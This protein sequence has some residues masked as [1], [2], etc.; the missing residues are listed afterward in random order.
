MLAGSPVLEPLA[1]QSPAVLPPHDRMPSEILALLARPDSGLPANTQFAVKP[2]GPRLS[3]DYI[4]QPYLA[5]GADRFGTFVGGGASLYWSDMLGNR[6]LVTVLQV[7]GG[8]KDVSALV[9]YLNSSHRWNWGVAAQQVP[10]YSGAYGASI[11]TNGVYIER[12]QLLRQ[13]NRQLAVMTAYPFN[14]VQ[15]VELSAGVN[16]ISF[17]QQ[18]ETRYTA[19]STGQLL[20]DTTES[21]QHPAAINLATTSGALVFDNSFFGATS[22]ILGQ[23]YRL[24]ADPTVGT[25]NW[26]G[27]LGDFRKYVMPVRPFTLAARVLHYGRYGSGAEDPRLAPLF[28][29]YPSLVRG[30]D[31]GSFSAAECPINSNTCPA[32]DR[33]LGSRLFVGNLELRF[34]LLGLLGVGS[35]YYGAFPI[36]AALFADGGVAYCSANNTGF[37]I[38]DNRAVS[39]AGLALRVN[40]LGYAIGEMDLVKPFQRPNKGWYLQFSL[41]PGF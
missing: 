13:I 41:T 26:V 9:A 16:N 35:G 5:V 31:Y 18:L 22:P 1:A 6:N 40:L 21:L 12:V 34:P 30:Y 11:D 4:A 23:R 2:Y 29:G 27:V 24:E 17:D 37:C 14:P 38:G 36:E 8:F 3:L 28:L 25:I 10:Y 20:F 33:L 32:F 7:N 15:R 39:S 19:L